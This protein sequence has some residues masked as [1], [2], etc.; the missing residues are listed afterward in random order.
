MVCSGRP[1]AFDKEEALGKALDLFWRN[2]YEGTSLSDLTK[3]MGINKPS[4]Y[5][6]FGNKEQL[7]LQAID[8]YEKRPEAYFYSAMQQS[9]AYLVTQALLR[10]AAE[11]MANADHPQ[12]C[13]II[14][15]ALACSEASATIK[16]ELIKRR[17]D[18][19]LALQERFE[20]AKQ[21]GDLPQHVNA[22]TLAAYIG[23][24]LQGM[25]VQANNGA[26][27]EDLNA[28]ADMVLQNFPKA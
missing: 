23:T 19:Q 14:Q 13:V 22:I 3:A 28:V 17:L 10:G 16:E 2:G 5:A 12:G 26:S 24:V 8:L 15:G 1:R 11:R 6:T 21:D 27:V 4:M 20:K 18:G 7:F 25:S 9:T